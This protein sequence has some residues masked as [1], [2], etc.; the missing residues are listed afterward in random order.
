MLEYSLI[1]LSTVLFGG[2]F[3]AL[4]F[5]QNKNGKSYR[6]IFLFCL[7]FAFVGA[8]L[9][10]CLARFNIHFSWYTFLYASLAAVIQIFLQ[11]VGIKALSLGKVEIYTLFNVAGGMSVAYL[12]GITYFNEPVKVIHIIGLILILLALVVPI[13]FDRKNK[14]KTHWIFWILCLLVFASNGFFGSVNK[15]HIMS[16]QGLSI[17]EYMFYVY[18]MIFIITSIC[19]ATSFIKYKNENKELINV[20]GF[21]FALLYGLVNSTGMF[22][23]YAFA[24]KVPASILFPLSNGGCIIFALII[25]S[26]VYR[27]I[28]SLADIIEFVIALGGMVLFIL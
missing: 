21:I 8:F 27:K 7:L 6:S 26:I 14:I 22:L 4:N 23:Q 20:K 28:P 3:I 1:I 10:L 13:I 5:Y 17:Y 11:I 16:G 24:D 12:F 2:Q 18:L 25:G 15:I 9:F 19:F